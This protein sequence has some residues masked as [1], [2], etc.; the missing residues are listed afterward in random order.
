MHPNA[1]GTIGGNLRLLA[2]GLLL[3][4]LAARAETFYANGDGTKTAYAYDWY[5]KDNWQ[6]M[7]A[8]SNL[9]AASSAPQQGDTVI[10]NKSITYMSVYPDSSVAPGLQRV[11]FNVANIIHQGYVSLLAGGDGLVMN[12]TGTMTWW[13]GLHLTGDGEVP[14]VVPSGA[15]FNNQKGVRVV[16][17]PILVKQGAG[18]F[19]TANEGGNE[20]SAKKTLLQ[21]GTIIMRASNTATGHEFV[22]DS[23]EPGLRLRFTTAKNNPRDWTIQNGS[24]T[25]CAE[26]DNTTH[27]LSSDAANGRL[28]YLRLTGTPK[29]AEQRFT[30]QLYDTAGIAFLPGAKQ[31][32]GADYVFTFAKAVSSAGGG[33]AVTNGTVRLTEGATFTNLQRLDVGATGTFK[34]ES[35]SGVNFLCVNLDVAAGGKLDLAAG[36]NLAFAQGKAGGSALATGTYTATGANGTTAADWITG[37][38]QVTVD[39][40]PSIDPIVLT[41][42]S[43]ETYLPEALAAYNAAYGDDVT[44]ASLNGGDDKLRTLVKRG[45]GRLNLTNAMAS[46]EGSIRVEEGTIFSNAKDTLGKT[47][48]ESH[49]IAVFAGAQYRCQA[50]ASNY[51]SGRIFRIQGSGPDGKGALYLLN[52][53]GGN[54]GVAQIYG[55]ENM[56]GKMVCLDGDAAVGGGGWIGYPSITLNGHDLTFISSS[57]ENTFNIGSIY[58][59]GNIYATNVAFRLNQSLQFLQATAPHTLL[60][61]K[62]AQFRF[63]NTSL[64]GAAKDMWHVEFASDCNDLF[65]DWGFNRRNEGINTFS[66]PV[67]LNKMI[68]IHGQTDRYYARV[69]FTSTVSGPG[70]FVTRKGYGGS[71]NTKRYSSWLHLDNPSNTFTGGFEFD[72][73]VIWSYCNGAIPANG[74]PVKII[75]ENATDTVRCVYDGVGFPKPFERYSLPELR[76]SGS[77]PARVQGGEGAWATIVKEGANTLE[78]YSEV[79]APRVEV[80]AGTFKLPRGAAPGL[81]EGIA[82]YS[83]AANAQNAFNGTATPTNFIVRGP[84]MANQREKDNV[85]AWSQKSL[86]TYKGYV[87]NRTGAPV[88][89]TFASSLKDPVTV[90]IDGATVLSGAAA[91]LATADV[92]LAPGPHA[93]EWRAWNGEDDT[94]GPHNPTGWASEFGFVYDAQGRNDT[95]NTNNFVLATDNGDGALFTRYTNSTERLPA[96][97]TMAFSQGATLDLNGNA[98]VANEILGWPVVTNTCTDATSAAALTITN[99]FTV[100]GADLAAGKQLVSS[101]PVTFAPGAT[102]TLTNAALI[103]RNGR[104]SFPVLTAATLNWN[105]SKLTRDSKDWIVRLDGDG[106]TLVLEY[107][108]GTVFI[109][110]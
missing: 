98:Y 93:F 65:G 72:R 101:V 33:V 28:Y 54:S 44:F 34:V 73:G 2:A 5:N 26:V 24:F 69:H 57:S 89:W 61:G 88:T 67:V 82:T 36:V 90:L 21:G 41:V 52:G 25:E 51:N 81:W 49:P 97:G 62:N 3:C 10:F 110:R 66:I 63:V 35:G 12:C 87:W 95:S 59:D 13:A 94:T 91:A 102:V 74:G 77:H 55:V 106:K 8:N 56:A 45:A 17:N 19:N 38:G 92:T 14:I 31:T 86:V 79:G 23:N 107:T 18:T 1:F 60:I 76:V 4:G 83:S 103:A 22:F 64:G 40:A 43:G 48:N 109:L 105:E 9:V 47:P 50:T 108:A 75:R 15:T 37:D 29:L 6:V 100:D 71:N 80:K 32:G 46:Y 85:A 58:G 84:H 78:Y 7:D 99:S 27:G 11:Q 20:Y 96:F 68:H 39:P 16:G 42:D 53:T 104:K 30:G 70:G